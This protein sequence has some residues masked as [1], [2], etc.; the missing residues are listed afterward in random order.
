MIKLGNIIEVEQDYCGTSPI[1]LS[2]VSYSSATSQV[3]F[4][5]L[6]HVLLVDESA[7]SHLSK[8]VY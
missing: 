3:V 5:Y 2:S 8:V 4:L 6:F 1:T 7:T